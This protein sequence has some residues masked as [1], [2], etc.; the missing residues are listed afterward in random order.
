MYCRLFVVCYFL[1]VIEIYKGKNMHFKALRLIAI[2]FKIIII[3]CIVYPN[4][5]DMALDKLNTTLKTWPGLNCRCV[6][7]DICVDCRYT[8]IYL[9]VFLL[10]LSL[11]YD[12]FLEFVLT[13]FYKCYFCCNNIIDIIQ[14]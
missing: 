13:V 14:M 10:L 12:N 9:F 7:I 4:Y 3:S 6:D 8:Y 1:T 11:Y 5:C 2:E